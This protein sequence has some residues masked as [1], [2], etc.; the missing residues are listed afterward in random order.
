MAPSPITNGRIIKNPEEISILRE[1]QRR[2]K[3]VHEQILPF[4]RVG[5]SEME[6]AR[7]IQIFQ[8]E[9]GASGPSFPPIVAF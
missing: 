5:V 1:S 3:L 6:I 4:L 7:K 2:N 9:N 8:L